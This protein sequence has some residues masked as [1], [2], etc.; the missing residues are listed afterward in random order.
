M[1]NASELQADAWE[2]LV[3]GLGVADAVRYRILF[4]PGRGDYAAERKALFRD[5][6]LD[7]WVAAARARRA[8]GE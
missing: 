2:A 6:S 1:R 4:E 3:K 8:E 7:D 5:M